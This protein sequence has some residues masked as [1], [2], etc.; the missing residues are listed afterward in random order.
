MNQDV[1]LS[2]E[3]VLQDRIT[4][5]FEEWMDH[6]NMMVLR[7]FGVDC[8]CLPDYNYWAWFNAGAASDEVV[9]LIQD[10]E[11]WWFGDVQ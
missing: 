8:S 1:S 11:S 9:D 6:V 2:K 5:S 10:Q 7:E 4:C 3:T